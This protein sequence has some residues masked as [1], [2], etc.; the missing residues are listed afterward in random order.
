M[1]SV[2]AELFQSL[3]FNQQTQRIEHSFPGDMVSKGQLN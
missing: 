1:L 3:P 2:T